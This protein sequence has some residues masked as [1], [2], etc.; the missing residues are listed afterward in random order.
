MQMSKCK[1]AFLNMFVCIIRPVDEVVAHILVTHCK[2]C[3]KNVIV[4]Y[5][6]FVKSKLIK[7]KNSKTDQEF[8]Y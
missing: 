8:L 1:E 2:Q 3:C 4:S 6:Y 5:Y 7:F